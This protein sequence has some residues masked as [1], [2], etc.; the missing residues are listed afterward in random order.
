MYIDVWAILPGIVAIVL[1]AIGFSQANKANAA[2]GLVIAALI[3]S[4]I[5]TAIASWQIYIFK[6]APSKI[7]KIGKEIEKAMKEELDEEDMKEL[8]EAMEE[9]EGEIEEAS[10]ENAEE[11]GR[12]AGKALKE[13]SDEVK[14]AQKEIEDD[15]TDE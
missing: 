1:S 11:I 15:T 2:K 12:A 10:E 9:L 7:E 3:I 5:G 13:F 6:S 14:K 8:E 4:I